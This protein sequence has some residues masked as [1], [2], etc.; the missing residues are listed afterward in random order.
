M[1]FESKSESEFFLTLFGLILCRLST[2]FGD[3]EVKAEALKL[4]EK[5]EQKRK[6]STDLAS[7]ERSR[8][9]VKHPRLN[10]GSMQKIGKAF[11]ARSPEPKKPKLN[12]HRSGPLSSSEIIKKRGLRELNASI[13]MI[14]ES[15]KSKSQSSMS[16]VGLSEE[17]RNQ[18]GSSLLDRVPSEAVE[19]VKRY[20]EQKELEKFLKTAPTHLIHSLDPAPDQSVFYTHQRS[21]YQELKTK[22][23]MP[24]A[25]SRVEKMDLKTEWKEPCLV[26]IPKEDLIEAPFSSNEKEAEEE[27]EKT[28]PKTSG[29]ELFSSLQ[30]AK[31]VPSSDHMINRI[32]FFAEDETKNEEQLQML[33]TAGIRNPAHFKSME[34]YPVSSSLT[35][36]NDVGNSFVESGLLGEEV[37]ATSQSSHDP[38]NVDSRVQQ[39][40]LDKLG[41][42]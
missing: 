29:I 4:Y 26:Q 12:R 20:R 37:K 6:G 41:L 17:S 7:G 23:V 27:R 1:K 5:W 42:L 39:E 33:N 3:K 8:K 40:R 28:V 10:Q 34:F 9:D 35:T 15:Y 21:L 18:S 32:P 30:E 36:Q 16:G 2:S 13:K 25:N 24:E 31:P 38:A 22:Q 14:D 19:A 11:V